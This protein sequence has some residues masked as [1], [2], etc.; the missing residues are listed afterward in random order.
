MEGA[1]QS[2]EASHGPDECIDYGPS[3]RVCAEQGEKRALQQ[4]KRGGARSVAAVGGF[5]TCAQKMRS[6]I[7]T[8]FSPIWAERASLEVSDRI[9]DKVT[10]RFGLLGEHPYDGKVL[11]CSSARSECFHPRT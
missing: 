10:D 8:R 1:E 6:A 2:R 4:R 9:I 3:C 5:V 11:A 7:S